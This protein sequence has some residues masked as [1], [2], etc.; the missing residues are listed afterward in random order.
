MR[1]SVLKDLTMKR[2]V[3]ALCMF[4]VFA[5]FPLYE[6]WRAYTLGVVLVLSKHSP[7]FDA[8]RAARPGEFVAAVW[9]YVFLLAVAAVGGA[10]CLLP[11]RSPSKARSSIR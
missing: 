10:A 3:V 1:R 8:T 4:L 5:A 6:L 11:D 2:Y 9:F 7:S